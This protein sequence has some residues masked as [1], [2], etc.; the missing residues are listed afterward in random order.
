MPVPAQLLVL[1]KEPLPGRVKTRLTPP[2]LPTQAAAVARAALL[3]TLSAVAAVPA[4]RR[5][6][7]LDGAAD[8]WLPEGFAVLPQHHG[9]LGSRLAGAFDDAYAALRLPM[10]LIGMDTPQVTSDLLRGA[11]TALLSPG[12][13]AVLGHAEDGGWWALGLRSPVDGLFDDV[14]MSTARAGAVQRARLDALG[15]A[16]TVLP[17]Q[18][19]IDHVQDVA[20]VAALQPVGARL[21]GLAAELGLWSAT[22]VPRSATGTG[23]A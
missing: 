14:P 11:L 12:T 8:G 15:L 22:G 19:D 21:A 16:T 9:D 1:A 13:D 7:V 6:V 5:T 2:L 10:L 18:R 4:A 17:A 3:D 23:A 20:A